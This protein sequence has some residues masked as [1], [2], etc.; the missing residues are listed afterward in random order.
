MTILKERL[1]PCTTLLY[2]W[3]QAHDNTAD[4][5]L[6]LGHF[7]AWTEEFFEK[8]LTTKEIDRAFVRLLQLQLIRLEGGKIKV[9]TANEQHA[10]KLLPLPE[11]LWKIWKLEERIAIGGAA[12]ASLILIAI[13]GFVLTQQPHLQ[14]S[15]QQSPVENIQEI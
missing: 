9:L 8:Q 11:K 5:A 3:L 12:I 10:V 6:N 15:S 7:Q 4:T 2:H 14:S 1:T 13:S